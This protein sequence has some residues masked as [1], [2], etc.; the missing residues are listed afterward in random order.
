V[1]YKGRAVRVELSALGSERLTVDGARVAGCGWGFTFQELQGTVPAGPGAGDKLRV[2]GQY[3]FLTPTCR[4][5]ASEGSP[6]SLAAA[7][8]TWA[9]VRR[10]ARPLMYV[11]AIVVPITLLCWLAIPQGWI[12]I[13][14]DDPEMVVRVDDDVFISGEHFTPDSG[15]LMR[16]RSLRTGDHTVRAYKRGRVV[17]E[18]SFHLGFDE[19]RDFDLTRAALGGRNGPAPAK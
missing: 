12:M 4:L 6:P 8:T 7:R 2:L 10:W 3:G 16:G 5:F 1:P 19:K 14:V 15:Y 18:E 17:F 13:K 11:G 9:R